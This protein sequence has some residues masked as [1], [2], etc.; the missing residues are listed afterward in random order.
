M[1]HYVKSKFES[2]PWTIVATADCDLDPNNQDTQHVLYVNKGDP[3]GPEPLLP[4]LRARA[5]EYLTWNVQHHGTEGTD[6]PVYALPEQV[7]VAPDRKGTP[8]SISE[9]TLEQLRLK[10]VPMTTIQMKPESGNR[11]YMAVWPNVLGH[12]LRL[13]A[14]KDPVDNYFST[15]DVCRLDGRPNDSILFETIHGLDLYKINQFKDESAKEPE[16]V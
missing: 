14:Y 7:T 12:T 3:L 16:F 1:E 4:P 15:D 5:G 2:S 11:F 8:T 6:I 10:C 13:K 9:A